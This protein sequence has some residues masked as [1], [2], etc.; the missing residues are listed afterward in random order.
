MGDFVKRAFWAGKNKVRC[1]GQTWWEVSCTA[2]GY[3]EKIKYGTE[4]EAQIVMSALSRSYYQGYKDAKE[5][6]LNWLNG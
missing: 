6:L 3:D 2:L 4:A 5:A 1:D